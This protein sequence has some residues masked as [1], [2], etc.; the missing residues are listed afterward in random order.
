M[1]HS[2]LLFGSSYHKY[3]KL[4]IL[5]YI[6][7]LLNLFFVQMKNVNGL[8][9]ATNVLILVI[10][11][12]LIKQIHNTN[13][14]ALVSICA[15]IIWSMII[16]IICYYAFPRFVG[17]A[18]L[19][20]YIGRGILFNSKYVFI[21]GIALISINGIAKAYHILLNYNGFSLKKIY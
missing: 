15:I 3:K 10:L 14:N 16:D 8:F 2:L 20:T 21:N 1:I 11:P 18:S 12:L 5:C 13:W 7:M 4:S 17:D 19:F 6:L 9:L